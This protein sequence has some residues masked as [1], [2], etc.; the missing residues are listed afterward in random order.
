MIPA[1]AF[2]EPARRRGFGFYTGVPCSFLTP[3]I[4]R[5]ISDR[6]TRYVGAASE[7]EALR[8][9]LVLTRRV[10]FDAAPQAIEAA[11]FESFGVADREVVPTGA[12]LVL[13][14]AGAGVAKD[15]RAHHVGVRQLELERDV[16]AE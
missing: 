7:G 6:N 10:D 15:E 16:A 4:N 14:V 1:D 11:L 8:R 13:A 2:L 5:V 3:I 9:A 12:R